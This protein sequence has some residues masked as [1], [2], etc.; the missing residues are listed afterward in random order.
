MLLRTTLL[1]LPAQVV[2]PLFQLVSVVAWTHVAGEST[3]G[4]ITL[5]TATHELLQTAFLSWWSQYALRF[6]GTVAPGEQSDRFYRTENAVLLVSVAVQSAVGL[7]ILRFEIV[8]DAGL[9]LSAAVVCYIVGRSFNLYLAE[10]ARVRHEILVYSIQQITGPVFGFGLGLALIVGLGES[11]LWPIAGYAAAQFLALAVALPLTRCGF[12]V[13]PVDRRL[14]REAIRYG[15]PLVLGGGLAWI[16]ANASR[17]V[18]SD[19]LGI[20]AA[21][22]F[23]VG[24]GLGWRAATVASMMVTASAFPIAVS[25]M[26]AGDPRRGMRQLSD[27]GA[28][29]AAILLPSVTGIVVLRGEL[30]HALIAAAFQ[31]ATLTVLPVAALAGGIR[32]FRAHFADQAYLLH[33]RTRVL[34]VI[35]GVEAVTTVALGILLVS[36]YGLIGGV[37]ANAV[38]TLVA[39]ILS[40]ALSVI[41]FKLRPPYAHLAR[42]ATSTAVMAAFLMLLPQARTVPLLLFH[43]ALGAAVY[44]AALAGLYGQT[45]WRLWCARKHA[46]AAM[47]ES[48]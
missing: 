10:R 44:A 36:W 24:Y 37:V 19:M 2:G 33:K 48:E 30:V 22:L 28:L 29:L 6:F 17:F 39:A 8:P 4:V 35:S 45:V 18:I 9:A 32:N 42:I 15:L 41:V 47:A 25:A 14:L 11:P 21:G 12:A 26:E 46:Q 38:A 23:A 13:G 16:T 3:L 5:I 40:F 31:P 34:V 20:G 1:Y 7:S 43:I 27:N